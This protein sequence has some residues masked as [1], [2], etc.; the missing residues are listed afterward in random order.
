MSNKVIG[1]S[2]CGGIEKYEVIRALHN[3]HPSLSI[4]VF[5]ASFMTV[6]LKSLSDIGIDVAYVKAP[7]SKETG[8]WE[9]CD[10]MDYYLGVNSVDLFFSIDT[11][12]TMYLQRGITARPNQYHN[13]RKCFS[14][15]SF[16]TTMG[17]IDNKQEIYSRIH[18]TDFALPQIHVVKDPKGCPYLFKDVVSDLDEVNKIKGSKSVHYE[19]IVVKPANGNGSRGVRVFHPNWDFK[20]EKSAY[21]LPFDMGHPYFHLLDD[22]EYVCQPFLG[23]QTYNVD[24]YVSTKGVLY[25]SEQKVLGDRWG[26]VTACETAQYGFGKRIWD[27]ARAIKQI[28]GA[29]G[30]FNFEVGEDK[31]GNMYLVEINPRIAATIGLQIK[32]GRDLLSI[33]LHDSGVTESVTVLKSSPVI[34]KIKFHTITDK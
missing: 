27:I 21:V 2:T 4:V 1:I 18:D 28:F 6:E 7:K 19:G 5:D 23:G 8:I 22:A 32:C 26:V 11:T 29:K 31:L 16:G 34:A 10:F 12:E 24:C 17:D 33:A 13:I 9:Y 14:Y 15:Q 25:V 20:N 3:A 30:F